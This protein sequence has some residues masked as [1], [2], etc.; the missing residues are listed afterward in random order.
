MLPLR[1]DILTDLAF[2]DAA[3]QM[4]SGLQWF[5]SGFLFAVW[6]RTKV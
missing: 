4:T 3:E 5:I 1:D 6:R 2:Y